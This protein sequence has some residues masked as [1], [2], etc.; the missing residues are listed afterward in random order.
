MASRHTFRF[1]A[2]SVAI[3]ALL[4]WTPGAEAREAG[5]AAA[6]N[7]DAL[8]RPPAQNERILVV[9]QNVVFEEVIKTGEN[10]QAQ[11]LML[12]QSAVTVA[13]NSEL[14]IDKFVYDPDKK[15]G[16]MALNLSRGL[17]RFVGGRLSKTG[18]VS[19][20]T[21]VA[22]IGIRGGVA[23]INVI[24]DTVV[25]VT[26]L[27]GEA[28]QG[29]TNTGQNF[30]VR[31]HG[32]FTRIEQ[33]KGA[34]APQPATAATLGNSLAK[35][36]GRASAAA[37]A[38]EK[39]TD[40][41]AQEQLGS[42]PV[43]GSEAPPTNDG[44]NANNQNTQDDNETP[45]G[46]TPVDETL[47]LEPEDDTEVEEPI[48]DLA[49]E[50][51]ITEIFTVSGALQGNLILGST[52]GLLEVVPVVENNENI[53]E[54]NIGAGGF[55]IGVAGS[56]VSNL[57]LP[58][59]TPV[60]GGSQQLGDLN[61]AD[62]EIGDRF[63]AIEGNEGLL[64]SRFD[65]Q[66]LSFSVGGA[67]DPDAVTNVFN[68]EDTRTYLS[69]ETFNANRAEAV[70][71]LRAAVIEAQ[72]VSGDLF[73]NYDLSTEDFNGIDGSRI[74]VFGGRGF[75]SLP[76][77]QTHFALSG[78]S[79]TA[80]VLPYSDIGLFQLPINGIDDANTRLFDDAAVNQTPLIVDWDKRKFMYAGGVFQNVNGEPGSDKAYGI[81]AVAGNVTGGGGESL[82]RFVG[83]N[84]GSSHIFLNDIETR[85]LHVG[86]ATGNPLGDP[87][88]EKAVTMDGFHATIT[89]NET[90]AG[91]QP[92]VV[93]QNHQFGLE[94]TTPFALNNPGAGTTIETLFGAIFIVNAEDELE[95]L[96]TN[97]DAENGPGTLTIDRDDGEILAHFHLH[98]QEGIR[99]IIENVGSQSAFMDDK[100]FAIAKSA[101]DSGF[102]DGNDIAFI[103]VAADAVLNANDRPCVCEFMHW[104]FIAG[105]QANPGE[106]SNSVSDIGVFFAG[107]P[108]PTIDMPVT[109]S[110]TFTGGAFASVL[111]PGLDSPQFMR[112]DFSMNVQFQ[113]GVSAGDMNLGANAFT[114]IGQHA[115]GNSALNVTY[116][117]DAANVGSGAGAF[118]GAGAQNLGVTIDIN[119]GAGLEAVGAAVAER[120]GG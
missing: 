87:N 25:D 21:P 84:V 11:L 105:G 31:R 36:E 70:G 5:V 51:N 109:G 38:P 75:L 34:S 26:L 65:G 43:G 89:P 91:Q 80:S 27:Y 7:T 56:S 35:L 88:G 13:P 50:F 30:S 100:T 49:Q 93:S 114:V 4:I 83:D 110:A 116:F 94:A 98:D 68:S 102:A 9:G 52:S 29:V 18:S 67:G 74:T 20:R 120:A 33:D 66:P 57:E 2:L 95:A 28:I 24:S 59:A 41:G 86:A 62:Q 69:P 16:E 117:Q 113:T 45:N 77:G 108:T 54:A 64:I 119:N 58:G 76:T 118:F 39:P 112:G 40:T 42:T 92:P 44:T 107:V 96:V 48:I 90:E 61:A 103:A 81:Q 46:E 19:V 60:G 72:N 14:T 104:G 79:Q 101:L 23:L 8:S 32:Y 10:G 78:D 47:V 71:G 111:Q 53:D 1:A 85:R 99:V 106:L 115:V 3:A 55:G 22:T 15:T 12:D 82:V 37:G 63:I 6:V 73:F 17:M 97:P